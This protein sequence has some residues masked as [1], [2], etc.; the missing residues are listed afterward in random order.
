MCLYAGFPSRQTI[1]G[2]VCNGRLIS[3]EPG[4]LIGI[5]LSF[6]MNHASVCETMMTAFVLEA[7]PVYTN[8][9]SAISNDVVAEHTEL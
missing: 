5:K 9:Q 8:F 4:N 6:Q 3:T 7:M 2:C 1:D